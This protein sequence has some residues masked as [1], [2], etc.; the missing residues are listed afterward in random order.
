M[1]FDVTVNVS[2][3]LK[4]KEAVDLKNILEN[5]EMEH[6]PNNSWELAQS[7]KNQLNQIL[8]END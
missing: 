4:L 6:V 3:T 5:V 2:L 1:N 7:L 8:K